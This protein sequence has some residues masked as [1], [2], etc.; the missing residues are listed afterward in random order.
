MSS[1]SEEQAYLMGY[2]RYIKKDEYSNV[3]NNNKKVENCLVNSNNR[4][5]LQF[6]KF[7]GLD[8]L[9]ET[10]VLDFL[11]GVYDCIGKIH[12]G[13]NTISNHTFYVHL[14][15]EDDTIVEMINSVN[16]KHENCVWNGVNA[17]EF[18]N[19]LYR[20]DMTCYNV[21]TYNDFITNCN[22]HL[23]S[24]FK[25]SS[26]L[27]LPKFKWSMNDEHAIAPTKNRFTD[28]G[29]DLHIIKFLKEVNGVHFYDTGIQVEPPHGFYFD[30]VA[31]SS[32][33]KLG[34]TLANNVGIID[35][36][37]RGSIKIALKPSTNHV[38]LKLPMKLVQL[39]PRQ[40][41]LME[42]Q[43]TNTLTDTTRSYKGFGSSN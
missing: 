2:S 17:L 43:Y 22:P 21:N 27:F 41:I 25:F 38:E 7:C 31:R 16:D 5:V 26:E 33:S 14:P 18:L 34:W 10:G 42:P 36:S 4:S 19:D 13:N 28:T 30:L 40:L 24:K 23:H 6:Y 12:T 11:R 29:F 35:A 8:K 9:D 3:F 15:V 1:I 37:Y 20:E 32:I 39:I